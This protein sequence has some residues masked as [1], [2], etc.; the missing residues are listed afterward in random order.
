MPSMLAT[1]E[2]DFARIPGLIGAT[3]LVPI[4]VGDTEGPADELA[5]P[6]AVNGAEV[7]APTTAV[8]AEPEQLGLF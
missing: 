7:A 3:G 1:L 8:A 4:V 2:A 5:A 6:T